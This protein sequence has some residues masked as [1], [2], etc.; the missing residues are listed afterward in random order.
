MNFELTELSITLASQ[1][2]ATWRAI[3]TKPVAQ[4]MHEIASH[5]GGEPLSGR[6]GK[7]FETLKVLDASKAPVRSLSRLSGVDAQP[8]HVDGSHLTTPPRYIILGCDADAADGWPP[9]QMLRIR[10]SAI[11]VPASR[12]E[13]FAVRN[14]RASFYAT[15]AGV[16]R[17]WVRFDPGCMVPKTAQGRAL[18]DVMESLQV[19]S[20]VSVKWAAGKILIID[21]WAMLHR[22]GDG[23]EYAERTLFR[24]SLRHF[25]ASF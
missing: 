3:H 13:A 19:Q 16:D 17:P 7:T 23:P 6:G 21:N 5:L 10:D 11:S 8:W 4:V 12:F 25:D 15:I 20:L 2:Y 18:L 24:I 1:G 22:R 9:T 14:G